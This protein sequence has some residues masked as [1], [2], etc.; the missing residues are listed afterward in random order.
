MP[1]FAAMRHTPG[2]NQYARAPGRLQ[3]VL[4]SAR[5]AILRAR[6]PGGQLASGSSRSSST[7]AAAAGPKALPRLVSQLS[8]G[9]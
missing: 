7:P 8:V 3:A 5:V 9:T 1:L 2:S 6:L 4:Q